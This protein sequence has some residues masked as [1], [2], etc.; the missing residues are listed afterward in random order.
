MIKYR[1]THSRGFTEFLSEADALNFASQMNGTIEQVDHIIEEPVQIVQ[2]VTP[3]QMRVAL[4]LSG[5][6]MDSIEAI[7]DGLGEP[8][9][10]IVR[11]TW[12]YSTEFQRDNPVLNQMAPL[13]GLSS[14][15]VDD[16]FI[17]ARQQ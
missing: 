3:R 8:Q 6:S 17:L 9:R 11:T 7:I 2:S 16:L 13:L 14:A 4:I 1:V 5:I 10:S 12:E 15:Q